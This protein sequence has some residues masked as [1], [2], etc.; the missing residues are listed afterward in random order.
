[1]FLTHEYHQRVYKDIIGP[2]PKYRGH[3]KK[4]TFFMFMEGLKP[5]AKTKLEHKKVSDQNKI[6]YVNYR[7]S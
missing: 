2:D 6:M 3:V 7:L 1:M 5:F 4:D